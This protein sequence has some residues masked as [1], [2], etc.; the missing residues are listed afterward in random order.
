[1]EH[2][3][4]YEH[5]SKWHVPCYIEGRY[6]PLAL[7]PLDRDAVSALRNAGVR[8]TLTPAAKP[9][10]ERTTLAQ[11]AHSFTPVIPGQLDDFI[12]RWASWFAEA[13][14]GQLAPPR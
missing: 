13:S 14:R 1:M 5:S 9:S 6:I 2:R 10:H 8:K 11:L 4:T 3:F 12:D 7:S